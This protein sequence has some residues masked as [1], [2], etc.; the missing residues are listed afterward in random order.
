M[1]QR[2]RVAG[3][4]RK[5]DELLL[6]KK[7]YGRLVDSVPVWELPTGK[8]AFGE[9]P[10]EA[11]GRVLYERVGIRAQ[12]I[13]LKDAVTFIAL[14]GASRLGNLYI[15]YDIELQND[16]KIEPGDRYSAYKFVRKDGYSGLNL[17]EASLTILNLEQRSSNKPYEYR[18]TVNG[19]TVYVDGCS[20]GNPGPSGIGYRVVDA[21]G[22][23]LAE[24]GEFV[25]FATSRVAEYYAMREG[26]ER[27]I[28]LGLKNVRFVSDNLMMVNQLNGVYKI[29]NS[30]LM[31]IY[32][33][34]KT[35]LY[36]IESCAFVHVKREHNRE[37]DAL[38]NEA[39]DRHFDMNVLK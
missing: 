23:V 7:R 29:K 24:G 16:Q 20:R 21:Y 28:S 35:M 8:I 25:G 17:D 32:D 27:A 18:E 5:K 19:A 22:R 6:M 13:A 4:V 38:A 9:Q 10:E 33:D 2:I 30:D 3:L 39:V 12:S 36:K 14:E 11:M 1:K 34:I 26:I 31:P 37:A 15:I